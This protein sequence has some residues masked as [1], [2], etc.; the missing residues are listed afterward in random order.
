MSVES[1]V[2]LGDVRVA[3]LL[4]DFDLS[5][6]SLPPV[7]F[8]ELELF[9]DLASYLLLGLLVEAD[10]HHCIS[11]LTNPFPNDIVLQII[12]GAAICPKLVLLLRQSRVQA[13]IL[14]LLGPSW[15][16]SGVIRGTIVRLVF[17]MISWLV[18]NLCLHFVCIIINVFLPLE[19]RIIIKC[20]IHA[21]YNPCAS[22][23]VVK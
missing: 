9:V 12:R 23:C 16:A 7:W 15:R 1:L 13:I 22:L 17:L 20:I 11:S 6:D 8:K 3:K 2:E 21:V 5:F 10:A 14:L 19:K 4:N 18:I